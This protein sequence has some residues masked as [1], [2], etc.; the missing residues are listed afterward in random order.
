M[1][2]FPN[3]SLLFNR[4]EEGQIAVLTS[5]GLYVN[6]LLPNPNYQT[7]ALNFRYKNESSNLLKKSLISRNNLTLTKRV[8]SEYTY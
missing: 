4:S 7:C 5:R 6:D 1:K 3:Q 2:Q 8:S